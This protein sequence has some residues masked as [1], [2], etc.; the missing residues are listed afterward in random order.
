MSYEFISRKY[1]EVSFDH[2]KDRF[3]QF[4]S[5]SPAT[6]ADFKQEMLAYTEFYLKHS[7]S[8]SMWLQQNFKLDLYPD[9]QQWIEEYV[10]IPYKQAGNEQLVFVLGAGVLA[11][12]QVIGA[13]EKIQSCIIPQ[14]FATQGEA[15]NWLDTFEV[16]LLGLDKNGLTNLSLKSESKEIM[17]VVKNLGLQVFLW[18]TLPVNCT[19]PYIMPKLI[20]EISNEN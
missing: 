8:L 19:Y 3:I 1:L 12:L 17:D 9:T 13:F 11:H 4:W 16:K 2:L 18:Q 6:I 5:E 20:G 7:P 15:E 14:H 10:N